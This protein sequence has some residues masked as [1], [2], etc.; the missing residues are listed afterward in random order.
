MIK[1]HRWAES[2]SLDLC[3]YYWSI[4]FDVFWTCQSKGMPASFVHGAHISLQ[5][6]FKVVAVVDDDGVLRS[7]AYV[8]S[9]EQLVRPSNLKDM[10]RA[11]P[12]GAFRT[13]QVPVSDVERLT[14]LIWEDLVRDA[15]VK[16]A[17]PLASRAR[18]AAVAAADD[19]GGDMTAGWVELESL[20]DIQ[21]TD[22]RPTAAAARTSAGPGAAATPGSGIG[23]GYDPSFLKVQ[24][25]LPTITDAALDFGDVAPLKGTSKPCCK[26]VGGGQIILHSYSL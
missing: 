21:L 19:D 23:K 5:A 3:Y 24:V 9:Q 14:G 12:V 2:S 17:N 7:S 11:L 4:A 16:T 18:A 8:V 10:Q 22:V 20:E 6:Y 13:F 25:P 1:S 26:G 15:D